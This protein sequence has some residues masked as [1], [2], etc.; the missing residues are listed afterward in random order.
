MR[1]SKVTT[2]TGDK[3]QTGLGDGKRIPKDHPNMVFLGDIDELNS[4]LGM[5]ITACKDHQLVSELKFIQQDLF[6][7]GGEASMPGSDIELLS[8]DRLTFLEESIEI[9]NA[10]LKPLKEFILPGGDEFSARIHVARAVCRRV[11]RSC[12]TLMN[13][14][15]D[16]KSWLTYLNRLSDY[17]FVMAR[18]SSQNQ[19]EDETLWERDK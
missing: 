16:V 17:F 6:N 18:F 9:M 7:L 12:V 10:K 8:E 13:T 19:G 5:A 1:I 2:K 4:F 14:G 15:V 3:G 11:E